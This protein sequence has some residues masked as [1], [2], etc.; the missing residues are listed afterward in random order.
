MPLI[1]IERALRLYLIDQARRSRLVTY[2][3]VAE[4]VRPYSAV[5]LER[6]FS[7]LHAW[8]GNVSRFEVAAGRPMLSAIVV[9]QDTGRPG[10]G[11]GP[12]AAEELGMDV[13]DESTFWIHQRDSVWKLWSGGKPPLVE[14]HKIA[15]H[16]GREVRVREYASGAIRVLVDDPPFVMSEAFLTRGKT[17][18]A[19]LK[20][21]PRWD[22][23]R[24]NSENEE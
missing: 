17:N 20:L 10:E 1:P 3:E 15:L 9:T 21:E 2:S 22:W 23:N 24:E 6:P 8:L 11:F 13:S 14:T 4:A 18:R 5:R 12:F 19:I 7:P 16:D